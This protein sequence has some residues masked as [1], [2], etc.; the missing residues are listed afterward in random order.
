MQFGTFG[1]VRFERASRHHVTLV[2]CAYFNDTL[3]L[4]MELAGGFAV[5]SERSGGESEC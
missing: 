2:S 4:E 5:H 3:T 1:H